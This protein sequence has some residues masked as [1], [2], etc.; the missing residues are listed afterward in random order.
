MNVAAGAR[1]R[2]VV[3]VVGVGTDVGKTWV[4]AAVL[5]ALRDEGTLVAARKPV[6]SFDVT[7]NSTD[8]DTLGRATGEPP[9]TVC[10]PARWYPLAMA[11]PIAADRLGR[12]AIRLADLVA[13]LVWPPAADVGIVETVGGL[14]SPLAH[15]GDSADLVRAIAPDHVILVADAALGAINA[16][17][18]TASAL[19]AP[20]TVMLNRFDPHDLVHETNR[21]W[22]VERDGFTVVTDVHGCVAAVRAAWESSRGSDGGTL[23]G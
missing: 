17:R 9:A 19:A 7:A 13:E 15:D 5:A 4:A 22:L 10:P 23:P 16:V 14:R 20:A 3:A 12:P 8:A 1:P 18:L 21:A 2:L 6:Q 11:P